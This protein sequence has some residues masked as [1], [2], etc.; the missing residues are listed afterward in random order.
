MFAYS[1]HVGPACVS[2]V[3]YALYIVLYSSLSFYSPHG[4]LLV[5][6]FVHV[7]IEAATITPYKCGTYKPYL[8][9]AA[10]LAHCDACKYAWMY[11]YLSNNRIFSL[12]KA[13][14]F[15]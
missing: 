13:S 7:F 9:K 8:G 11:Q 4:H 12:L 6:K 5:M 15:L 2:I 1:V 14:H 3:T 10:C